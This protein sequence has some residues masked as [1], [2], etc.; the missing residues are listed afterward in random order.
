MTV[1]SDLL[2]RSIYRAG[3][4]GYLAVAAGVVEKGLIALE[5]GGSPDGAV[6][7][8]R[9][10]RGERPGGELDRDGVPGATGRLIAVVELGSEA[11]EQQW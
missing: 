10:D 8:R 6:V 5:F 11:D 9:L 7:L 4:E 2:P 3:S 1:C